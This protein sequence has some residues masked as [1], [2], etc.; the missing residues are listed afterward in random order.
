MN[1]TLLE[2]SVMSFEDWA[3]LIKVEETDVSLS[4]VISA[5]PNNFFPLKYSE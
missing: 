4:Q 3:R 1:Y 5:T 2:L